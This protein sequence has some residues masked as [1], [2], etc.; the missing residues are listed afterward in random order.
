M[1]ETMLTIRGVLLCFLLPA[2]ALAQSNS[3]ICIPQVP[4]T[5][6]VT[7]NAEARYPRAARKARIQGRVWLTLSISKAGEVEDVHV[8]SGPAELQDAAVEA[9]RRF[10]FQPVTCQGEPVSTL[11]RI[12]V[13]FALGENVKN[14]DDP[15]PSDQQAPETLHGSMESHAKLSEE[16]TGTLILH[17]VNPAYPKAAF[18]RRIQGK[19]VLKIVIGKDGRVEAIAVIS[20]P[21]ELVPSAVGAVEQWVY[22]PYILDGRPVEVDSQITVTYS[23]SKE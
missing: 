14:A 7:H 18:K 8:V 1:A 10:R 19:V 21:P 2:I 13:D 22:R 3:S 4:A 23:L 20:G 11:T 6:V 16:L 17:H 9:A 15:G 5:P 12:P